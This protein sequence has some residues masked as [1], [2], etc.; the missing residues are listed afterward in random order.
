VETIVDETIDAEMKIRVNLQI[1]ETAV[2][3]KTMRGN[4]KL[5]VRLAL[6]ETK[7]KSPI[8]KV[9]LQPQALTQLH[10]Y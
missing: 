7:N 6:D 5:A 2:M 1:I 10:S 9:K 3:E 4:L 8:A